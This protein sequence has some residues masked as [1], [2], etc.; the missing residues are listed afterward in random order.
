MKKFVF[1]QVG[2]EQSASLTILLVLCGEDVACAFPLS[3]LFVLL[4]CHGDPSSD[5]C[6]CAIL[7]TD[8]LQGIRNNA[9]QDYLGA[10][11]SY[12]TVLGQLHTNRD[13]CLPQCKSNNVYCDVCVIE[14]FTM[15]ANKERVSPKS[16]QQ[17]CLW[18]A[19][20][21]N[22]FQFHAPALGSE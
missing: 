20:K 15:V 17:S 16:C 13:S 8:F 3:F 21:W 4:Q 5:W 7:D 18:P 10:F 2:A 9:A 1:S 19:R 6:F 11:P 22:N 14:M 12:D